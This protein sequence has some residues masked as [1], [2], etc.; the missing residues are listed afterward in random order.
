MWKDFRAF[1]M[2]GNVLDMA[3]GI[4]IGAAFGKIVTSFTNDLLMPPIGLALGK[5]D[6]SSF[7][8]NLS[9]T[10]YP[11]L[12]AARSAGAPVIAYGQFINVALDFL[13]I[14]FAVFLLVRGVERMRRKEEAPP[15]ATTRECPECLSEIPIAA[16]RCRFCTATV[17][18]SA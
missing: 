10:A 13:I 1:V 7:F 8:L 15:A 6:F 14:A 5:V 18:A 12:T 17:R 3:V 11:S 2:R 4:V 9:G 16:S